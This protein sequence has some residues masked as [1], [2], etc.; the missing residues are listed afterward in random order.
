MNTLRDLNQKILKETI[1]SNLVLKKLNEAIDTQNLKVLA[2]QLEKLNGLVSNVMPSFNSLKQ[3]IAKAE[4]DINSSV[5]DPK[6]SRDITGKVVSF[7]SKMWNFLSNDLITLA[8][9]P[10]L[11]DFFDDKKT[12]D[13]NATLGNSPSAQEVRKQIMTALK[14]DN[15][16]WFKKALAML[17]NNPNY[18]SDI[19]YLDINLF[20]SEFVNLPKKQLKTSLEQINSQ[21][22]QIQ[23]PENVTNQIANP[24]STQQQNPSELKDVFNKTK[25]ELNN[26]YKHYENELGEKLSSTNAQVL[27]KQLIVNSFM[28]NQTPE[29]LDSKIKSEFKY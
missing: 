2:D 21:I 11:R 17:S 7:Y 8:R 29:Q 22:K 19:P 26:L 1:D 14:A 4:T 12:P 23:N 5:S 9:L 3:A 24:K 16:P 25:V 10:A 15:S 18:V 13:E 6:K 20:S 27:L 28:E